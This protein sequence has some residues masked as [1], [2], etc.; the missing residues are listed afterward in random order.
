MDHV[1][2]MAMGSL[3]RRLT[4]SVNVVSLTLLTV[5]AAQSHGSQYH[6]RTR[7]AAGLLPVLVTLSLHPHTLRTNIIALAPTIQPLSFTSHVHHSLNKYP[8]HISDLTGICVYCTTFPLAPHTA[9]LLLALFFPIPTCHSLPLVWSCCAR[10]CCS[11]CVR[12]CPP[13]TLTAPTARS[14]CTRT[15]AAAASL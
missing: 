4:E 11:V 14:L 7:T 2:L 5:S 10:C 1:R 6:C 15:R 12:Y 8:S 3:S 9:L 13:R